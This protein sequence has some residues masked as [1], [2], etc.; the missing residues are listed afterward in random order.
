[1]DVRRQLIDAGRNGTVVGRVV[2]DTK[3]DWPPTLSGLIVGFILGVS[4]LWAVQAVI[5]YLL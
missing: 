3:A 4:A 5:R 1:M 2:L